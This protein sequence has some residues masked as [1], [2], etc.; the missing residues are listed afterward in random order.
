M[1]H[2]CTWYCHNCNT[3]AR[4]RALGL[5]RHPAF[6]FFLKLSILH[7]HPPFFPAYAVPTILLELWAANADDPIGGAPQ[8]ISTLYNRTE[9]KPLQG[10][11]PFL[12]VADSAGFYAPVHL[13]AGRQYY[14]WWT[15]WEWRA[16]ASANPAVNR[17]VWALAVGNDIGSYSTYVSGTWVPYGQP[18]S[19][20]G[21]SAD[22]AY[23]ALRTTSLRESGGPFFPNTT[24]AYG[25]ADGK[26]LYLGPRTQGAYNS[27]SKPGMARW[28]PIVGLNVTGALPQQ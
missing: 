23:H 27:S 26:Y 24:T 15:S 1:H 6:P 3:D 10:T 4:T 11:G 9:A 18:V 14:L 20:R 2:A 13:T 22:M 21:A 7:A 17:H 28:Y 25:G 12:R 5:F 19:L 8:Y 16:N